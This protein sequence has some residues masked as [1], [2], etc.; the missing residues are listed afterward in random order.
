MHVKHI[1]YVENERER[2]PYYGRVIGDKRG[3]RETH[4]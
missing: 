3:K 4:N 1:V 2:D